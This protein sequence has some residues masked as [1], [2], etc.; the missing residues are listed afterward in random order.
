[1]RVSNDGYQVRIWVYIEGIY[2]GIVWSYSVVV[3]TEDFD[4]VNS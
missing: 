3:I 1:M 4:K 2:W